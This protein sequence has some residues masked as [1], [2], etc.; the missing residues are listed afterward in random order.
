MAIFSIEKIEILL[1]RLLTLL[2]SFPIP[3]CIH[4]VRLIAIV[5]CGTSSFFLAHDACGTLLVA[6]FLIENYHLLLSVVF[7]KWFLVFVLLLVH[8]L[9]HRGQSCAHVCLCRYWKSACDILN[10]GSGTWRESRKERGEFWKLGSMSAGK[11]VWSLWR[12][13]EEE[14]CCI[15]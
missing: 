15:F 14:E 10:M 1:L 9:P 2:F 6:A 8:N 3:N 13:I 5:I 11:M 7:Q 12:A 4:E